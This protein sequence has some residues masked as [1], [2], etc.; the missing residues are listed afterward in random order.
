MSHITF[1][2]LLEKYFFSK[3]LRPTTEWSYQKVVN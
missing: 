2:L 1:E 3:S